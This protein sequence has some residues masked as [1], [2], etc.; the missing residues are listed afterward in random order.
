MYAVRYRPCVG[1]RLPRAFSFSRSNSTEN[2]PPEDS[3][4]SPTAPKPPSSARIASSWGNIVIPTRE[5]VLR[6]S[7]QSMAQEYKPD[8]SYLAAGN[9]TGLA[10]RLAANAPPPSKSD[11]LPFKTPVKKLVQQR[12]PAPTMSSKERASRLQAILAARKAE[13]K[14]RD[15]AASMAQESRRAAKEAMEA[16]IRAASERA[17]QITSER[18]AQRLHREATMSPRERREWYD[19]AS[20]PVQSRP[21]GRGSSAGARGGRG[22][23]PRARGGRGGARGGAKGRQSGP[24]K[25]KFTIDTL[26]SQEDSI[27]NAKDDITW[28]IVEEGGDEKELSEFK[29]PDVPVTDLDALFEPSFQVRV[30]KMISSPTQPFEKSQAHGLREAFGGDYRRIAP[31]NSQDF[32]TPPHSLGPVKHAQLVLSQRSDVSVQAQNSALAIIS[33]AVGG[34]TGSKNVQTTIN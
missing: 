7:N 11:S 22:S 10:G 29:T 19:A 8:L 15:E 23:V 6:A 21:E 5:E 2:P 17:T 30:E 20:Q 4:T 12:T 33:T 13:N 26:P 24:R 32:I 9:S 25:P 27:A 34:T 31:Q 16:D 3:D 28:E 14:A 18:T 1:R